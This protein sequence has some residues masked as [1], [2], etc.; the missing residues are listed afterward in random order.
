MSKKF[1]LQCH[2]VPELMQT[3]THT[4]Q[5]QVQSS[6]S[7]PKAPTAFSM[8]AIYIYMY[9]YKKKLIIQHIPVFV[10]GTAC[11]QFLESF[12]YKEAEAWAK[13]YT[14]SLLGYWGQSLSS[15]PPKWK[16]SKVCE[17]QLEGMETSDSTPNLDTGTAVRL[18]V[19]TSFASKTALFGGRTLRGPWSRYTF[20][21]GHQAAAAP[22]WLLPILR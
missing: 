12:N 5:A 4:T 15:F 7:A 13:K 17:M 11:R 14:P 16:G 18:L 19:P 1:T 2:I 8:P 9:I 20:L 22:C 10:C 3:R 6:Q 21:L